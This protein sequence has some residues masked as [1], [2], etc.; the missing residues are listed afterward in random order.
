VIVSFTVL[1]V[2]LSSAIG[3]TVKLVDRE[4]M[5]L[6]ETVTALERLQDRVA[7]VESRYR[8]QPASSSDLNGRIKALEDALRVDPVKAAELPIIRNEVST[9]KSDLEE[10]SLSTQSEI[11]RIED[12]TKWF[13][14]L[15]ITTILGFVGLIATVAKTKRDSRRRASR[16]LRSGVAI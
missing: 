11:H 2:F 5:L 3:R 13:W 16:T 14:G 9:L 6:E 7:S 15:I 1:I 8:I 10:H 4:T 12:Q